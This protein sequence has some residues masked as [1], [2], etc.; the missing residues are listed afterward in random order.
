MDGCAMAAPSDKK[1][2]IAKTTPENKEV[3][4]MTKTD[5]LV[6]GSSAAGL[7]A[8]V[9]GKASYP[10]KAFT[11][12][13]KE[14]KTLVPCGIPYFTGSKETMDSNVMPSETMFQTAGINLIIE[15][16][17]SLDREKKICTLKNNEEISFE[18]LIFATGSTPIRPRWLKGAELENVFVIPKD[19]VYLDQMKEK[20]KGKKK[21]IVIGA[22]FIGVELSD[23]LCQDGMEVTLVEKLPHI[24]G[25][26]FDKDLAQVA[27]EKLSE[28]GVAIKTGIGVKEVTGSDKA[29]GVILENGDELKA[30]A[31]FLS[32]GYRPNTDLAKESGMTL[33]P[34]GFIPVDEYMRT[35]N[36]DI[37]AAGDCAGKRDFFTGKPAMTML[38]ST[39]C[40]EARIAG[41][42][43]FDLSAVKKTSGTIAVFSTA[44]GGTGF[45]A[46]GLTESRAVAEGFDVITAAFEGMDKHP[47]TLP[48][49]MKQFVKLI[50]AKKSG[51]ILGGE[52]IGGDS[53]GELT[54]V[55]GFII[56]NR[57]DINALLTSQFGTHPLLTASPAGYPLFKAAEM[58]ARKKWS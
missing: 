42:N 51:I 19:K 15:E 39:A 9:T 1:S 17:V 25:M 49:T 43:L 18:K 22:G 3:K 40:T 21:I 58:L 24:L 14:E 23:E 13:R 20:L 48:G 16:A 37:F 46:A 38:A 52:I 45:G 54:N 41:L 56:Q 27:A 10:D 12:V 29:T 33:T 34:Q 2:S 47:G 36:P 30:D 5:V 7:V 4:K 57:M 28:R 6:I 11:V 26:A 32:M 31:V 44:I 50:A 35:D 8:A 53:T 55:I